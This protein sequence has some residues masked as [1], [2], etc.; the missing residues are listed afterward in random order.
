MTACAA[1]VVFQT[2]VIYLSHWK[3]RF[4]EEMK[5]QPY[6]EWLEN[7]TIVIQIEETIKSEVVHLWKLAFS[8]SS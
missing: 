1:T 8:S 2:F 5:L 6:T 3:T 4:K 7:P